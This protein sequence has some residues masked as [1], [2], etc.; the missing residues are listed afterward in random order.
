MKYI[1][2]VKF[3]KFSKFDKSIIIIYSKNRI[4]KGEIY[5]KRDHPV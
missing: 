3:V 5:E 1:I 4:N 2:L